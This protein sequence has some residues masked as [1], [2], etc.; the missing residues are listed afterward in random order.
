MGEK[1]RLVRALA[2]RD[3]S[4]W[5]AWYEC[6]IGVMFGLVYHLVGRDRGVAEDV[7]QEV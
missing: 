2:R 4:V 5:A 1:T 3:P 7:T 6:H